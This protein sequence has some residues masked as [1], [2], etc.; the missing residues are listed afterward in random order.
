MV[1]PRKIVMRFAST[2]CAVSE[3]EFRTPHSRIKLPNIKNPTRLTD[4]GATTP[5]TTVVR[6][7]KRI[8]VVLL[9]DFCS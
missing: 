1:S 2:F 6:I 8:F 3:R 9:T 7:G 4:A 5:A